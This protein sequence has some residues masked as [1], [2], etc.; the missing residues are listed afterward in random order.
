LSR[1]VE[2]RRVSGWTLS[3]GLLGAKPKHSN[4]TCLRLGMNVSRKALALISCRQ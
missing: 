2:K 1:V 4:P 3:A